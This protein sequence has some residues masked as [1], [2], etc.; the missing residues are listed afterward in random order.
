[1]VG[2]GYS[3][4]DAFVGVELPMD[5]EI[6]AAAGVLGSGRAE[7]T[8]VADDRLAM[9]AQIVS[10]AAAHLIG[11]KLKGNSIRPVEVGER[12]E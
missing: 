11:F 7:A 6:D 3:L 1:M 4:V 9:I 5:S 10:R 2:D 12:P 8:E